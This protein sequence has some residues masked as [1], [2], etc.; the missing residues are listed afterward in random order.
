MAFDTWGS[1][2]YPPPDDATMRN[3]V[4]RARARHGLG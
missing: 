3:R 4:P 2:F 1:Y